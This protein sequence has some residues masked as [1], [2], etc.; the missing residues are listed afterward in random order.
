LTSTLKLLRTGLLLLA[1]W[2]FMFIIGVLFC[3]FTGLTLVILG[4]VGLVYLGLQ[5]LLA[6][7]EIFRDLARYPRQRLRE[8]GT[9]ISGGE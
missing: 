5:L 4:F 1:E 3:A 2:V 6:F 7:Y 9:D 8:Q